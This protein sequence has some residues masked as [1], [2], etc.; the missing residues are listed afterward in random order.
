M[1]AEPL[2]E[3]FQVILLDPA[4]YPTATGD[5]EII[6]QYEKID[7]AVSNTIGIENHTV[8]IGLQYVFDNEYDPTASVLVNEFAIKFTTEPPF[9]NIITDVADGQADGNMLH[10]G[11]YGLLQ[12]H[13]NPFMSNTWI[14]YA[15]PGPAY[16]T[17]NI[18]DIRGALVC[19][20]Y[21]GQQPEGKYSV[22]WN[23]LNSA[24]TAVSAGVYFCRLQTEN[25]SGTMK[26]F[27][28]K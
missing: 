27:M 12:N 23:G 16:V 15:L 10:P 8:D 3:Y 24:G 22:E 19:S 28:L 26:M 17:I 13:P 7:A 1:T 6:V 14:D 9:E 4:Y 21:N 5:G 18:Y 2:K 11:D 20:L 25:Y